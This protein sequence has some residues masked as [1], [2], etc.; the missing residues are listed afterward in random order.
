MKTHTTNAG[1]TFL[2]QYNDIASWSEKNRRRTRVNHK[3]SWIAL[4]ALIALAVILAQSK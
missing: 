2:S 1:D 3:P 4:A